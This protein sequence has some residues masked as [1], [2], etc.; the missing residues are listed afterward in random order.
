[1]RFHGDDVKAANVYSGTQAL[2]ADD[3]AETVL[4]AAS[5]PAHVNIN[6]IQLM[7]VCQAF[8]PFAINREN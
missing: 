4:W 7:P 5:R 3:V 6:S 1:V 2:N 8:A